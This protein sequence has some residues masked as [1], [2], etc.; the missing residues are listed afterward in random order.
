MLIYIVHLLLSGCCLI[1]WAIVPYPTIRT[2]PNMTF[3]PSLLIGN[4][5][6]LCTESGQTLQGSFSSVSKP[7]IATKYAFE[8]SRRDLHNTL[9]RT[10][11]LSQKFCQIFAKKLLKI[12][13]SYPHFAKFCRI[14]L[15]FDEI[16]SKFRR[17]FAG[18]W[19]N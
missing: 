10:A 11:L 19:K 14:L 7:M 3:E 16:L 6:D 8:T 1:S 17:N 12:T 2:A 4:L 15:N 9:L 13:K 18:I 5:G